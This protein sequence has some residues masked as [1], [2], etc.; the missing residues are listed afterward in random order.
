MIKKTAKSKPTAHASA[1]APVFLGVEGGASHTVAIFADS[2]GRYLKRLEAGPGNVC[3]LTDRQL[4]GLF[5][6][7]AREGPSPSAIAVG[8]SGARTEG[9]RQRIRTAA[10]QVWPGIPC[11]ATHD[12]DTALAAVGDFEAAERSKSRFTPVTSGAR[13]RVLVLSGTGSCCYGRSSDGESIKVGGWGHWLGDEGSGYKLSLAAM[14]Q[15]IAAFDQSGVWPTLGEHLLR[16][17]QL[18]EPDDLIGFVQHAAKPEVAALATTVFDAAKAGDRL[19]DRVVRNAAERLA[20]QAIACA[21]RVGSRRKT[22][23][24]SAPPKPVRFVFVG[25]LLVK[26]PAYARRVGRILKRKFPDCQITPLDRE[27]AWGAVNL[28]HELYLG[29]SADAPPSKRVAPPFPTETTPTP[30]DA[31]LLGIALSPTEQRNPRSTT[32]D[33]MSIRAAIELM[34]SEEAT[35]PKAI[36]TQIAP[37]ES[38]I[39]AVIQAFRDGKRLWYIGAGTSGRLGV[40]DASECPPTFRTPP[41]QVQGIMAGGQRALWDSIEG[42]EDDPAAGA[43]AV[44]YRGVGRGDVLVGIAAS[45]R[46]PYVWGALRAARKRG[47]KTALVAFNPSH[48]IPQQDRP[49]F[50]IVP[51][52]GPEILTGSTRLKAGTATKL[53]LNM[54]TTLAMTGVGKVVSNLMVDLYPSNAKLQDRAVRIVCQLLEVAPDPARAAL[55]QS[56]W[57]IKKA[58][59]RLQ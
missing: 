29:R 36:L 24:R 45:G 54:I 42:A 48:P 23:R 17:L 22:A 55:E 59:A 12:L 18:N 4:L 21:L 30:G 8:M 28:A 43:R 27:S 58:L 46:T 52:V 33:R 37:L 32:L 11:A 41:D 16:A 1:A 50:V 20:Q 44:V 31:T 7:I 34:A 49:D 47:A 13:A 40:L 51:N 53:I 3:L 19:A 9:D 15:V 57:V 38:L 5:R 2:Q 39:K 6:D 14:Q 56:G 10:Q 26:E 35:I 25:S